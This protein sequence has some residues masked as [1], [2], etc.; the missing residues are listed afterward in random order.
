MYYVI[1]VQSGTSGAVIPFVFDNKADA[2]S[3]YHALLSVAATSDVPKHGAMLFNDDLFVS[4]QEMYC[5]VV[6]A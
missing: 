2:E 4:K 6:D 3:K 5:H 1:E